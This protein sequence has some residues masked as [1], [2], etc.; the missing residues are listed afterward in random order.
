MSMELPGECREHFTENMGP[1]TAMS[2]PD[3]PLYFLMHHG[4][5]W[6]DFR[7]G[8]CEKFLQMSITHPRASV[9]FNFTKRKL[10]GRGELSRQNIAVIKEQFISSIRENSRDIF[11][12][13][14]VHAVAV[15]GGKPY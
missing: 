14:K 13:D 12:F 15:Q 3:P 11:S 1:C 7:E 9:I 6:V 2:F 8:T 10:I 5:L 4:P